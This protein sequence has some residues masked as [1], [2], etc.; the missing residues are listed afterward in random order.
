MTVKERIAALRDKMRANGIDAYIVFDSDEHMSE[1]LPEY[2]RERSWISGF[3]GSA[4]TVVVTQQEAGLWT[5]G[6]YYLQAAS[7]LS[8]SG[9]TLFRASDAGV[10]SLTDYLFKS[11]ASG[12]TIALNGRVASTA[13]VLELREKCAVNDITLRTDLRLVDE[14]W[15][16][17]RPALPSGMAFAYPEDY[18]GLSVRKKLQLVR[19]KM[20]K[21]RLDYYVVGALDSLCWLYNLRGSD[22]DTS[23]LFTGFA[24]ICQDEAVLFGDR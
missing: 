11:V 13:M 19:E 16:E 10:I 9:V 21:L 17:D 20:E 8:G 6:R 22:V 18:A 12:G 2:Y 24:M 3:T 15:T 7:Q 5:D 14:L 23:P 1:Y 4:G